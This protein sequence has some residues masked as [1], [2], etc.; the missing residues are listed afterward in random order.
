[1]HDFTNHKA[2]VSDE[3]FKLFE[4]KYNRIIIRLKN[5]LTDCE[6]NNKNVLF[7]RIK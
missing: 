6:R 4:E 1:M 2:V 7:M 5:I 3:E